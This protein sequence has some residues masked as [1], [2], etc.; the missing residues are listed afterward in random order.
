[1]KNFKLVINVPS[2]PTIFELKTKVKLSSIRLIKKLD[3]AWFEGEVSVF[4]I[5]FSTLG[6]SMLRYFPFLI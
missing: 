5:I 4:V 6:I 3:D 2:P 1:M